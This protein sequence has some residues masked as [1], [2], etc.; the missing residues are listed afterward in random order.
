MSAEQFVERCLDWMGTLT[1]SDDTRRELV[2]HAEAGGALRFDSEQAR[3]ES[4]ARLVRMLQ[5][6]VSSVEYQFA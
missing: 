3:D 1:V 4:S 2:Q 6:I 5:A